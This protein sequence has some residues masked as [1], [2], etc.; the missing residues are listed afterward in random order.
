MPEVW[1]EPV[2]EASSG[3]TG[4]TPAE[5]G[6]GPTDERVTVVIP[7]HS[8]RRW[9]GLRLAVESARSQVPA[10][11][12][13]VVSVDHD[14]RLAGRVKSELPGI[15]VVCNRLTAGASGTRNFGA[16]QARTPLIAFLDSDVRPEGDWLRLLLQPFSVPA[17]MG[18]GGSVCPAWHGAEPPWFPAEFGWVVGAN[19]TGQPTEE[20]EVRNVWSENMAVR[21]SVF[22]AVGGFSERIG[23][24][25]DNS[26]PEDT[27][28]CLR[29][30]AAF[31]GCRWILVPAARVH[32]DVPAERRTV[33]FFLRRCF[34]E[35]RG[36]MQLAHLHRGPGHLREESE[37]VMRT[38]PLGALRSA[39]C[40]IRSRD[41]W[42][43]ARAGVMAGGVGAAAAGALV[44]GLRLWWRGATPGASE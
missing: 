4:V 13:I 22:Q 28:F 38:V 14:V 7:I 26:R 2:G 12:A 42:A 25:G 32:H 15:G 37:Y 3:S 43:A 41:P 10:P 31:P 35:G 44:E 40:A 20:A 9:A 34:A 19:F 29:T 27:D 5:A 33:R 17:V 16:M 6:S 36:K 18:T 21:T 23:K 1:G 8:D 11:A 30:K 24:V 39:R